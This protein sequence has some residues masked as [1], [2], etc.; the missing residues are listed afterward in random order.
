MIPETKQSEEQR[1]KVEEISKQYPKTAP[2][3]R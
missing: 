3:T 1:N 2:V